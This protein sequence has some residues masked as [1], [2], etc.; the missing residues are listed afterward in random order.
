MPRP[1]RRPKFGLFDR[2]LVRPGMWAD[3]LVFDAA[4]VR[5]TARPEDPEQAPVGIPHVLVNGEF[6]VRD[7]AYTGA[8]AGKVLRAK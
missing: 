2:G 1:S 8:R 4:A 7:G 3:L 6:A 5:D